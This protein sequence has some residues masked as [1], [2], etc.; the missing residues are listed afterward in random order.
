[1]ESSAAVDE[2][3]V[4]FHG[5]YFHIHNVKLYTQ[6]SSCMRIYVAATRQEA[7]QWLPRNTRMA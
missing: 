2:G 3:F 4:N 5:E 6:P 1:M 7:K